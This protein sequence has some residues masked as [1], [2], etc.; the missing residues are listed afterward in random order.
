VIA[1]D[2]VLPSLPGYESARKPAIARFH[3]VLPQAVVLCRTPTDVS[4]TISFARRAGLRT[5]AR[6]GGTASP[7]ALRPKGS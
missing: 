5:A 1:G 3:D 6:S 7:G 2:V 4:E